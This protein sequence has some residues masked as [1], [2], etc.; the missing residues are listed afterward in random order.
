[1]FY[2]LSDIITKKAQELV[3]PLKTYLS[4]NP[5]YIYTISGRRNGL[6][7][8]SKSTAYYEL[9]MLKKQIEHPFND[10]EIESE[11]YNDLDNRLERLVLTDGTVIEISQHRI[12]W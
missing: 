3:S 12:L 2:S 4:I 5:V 10:Q 11:D 7:Y 8:I 9:E 1:M 6:F